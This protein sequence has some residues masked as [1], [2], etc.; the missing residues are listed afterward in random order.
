MRCILVRWCVRPAVQTLVRTLSHQV[1][2]QLPVVA[3]CVPLATFDPTRVTVRAT[4]VRTQQ[5][6][7]SNHLCVSAVQPSDCIKRSVQIL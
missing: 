7:V 1:V 4:S 2:L 3:A 6:H 5:A